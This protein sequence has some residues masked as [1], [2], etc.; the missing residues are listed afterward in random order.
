MPGTFPGLQYDVEIIDLTSTTPGSETF[1][2]AEEHRA[3]D[4]EGDTKMEDDLG[5]GIDISQGPS[6]EG[7]EQDSRSTSTPGVPHSGNTDDHQQDS[8]SFSALGIPHSGDTDD[9]QQSSRSISASGIQPDHDMD[10]DHTPRRSEPPVTQSFSL[11]KAGSLPVHQLLGTSRALSVVS[12]IYVKQ[13]ATIG[14]PSG[15]DTGSF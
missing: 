11:P 6:T 10:G 14:T 5:M 3:L 1:L 12:A 9:H 8:R 2:D 4:N 15:V 7:H 13:V